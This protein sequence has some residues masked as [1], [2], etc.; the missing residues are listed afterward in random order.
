MSPD[1]QV[2]I[3]E[4]H[5]E[6]CFFELNRCKAMLCGKDTTRGVRDRINVLIETNVLSS[7]SML[8]TSKISINGRQ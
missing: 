7:P 6:V 2:L 3:H 1:I 5:P 4:L 8:E